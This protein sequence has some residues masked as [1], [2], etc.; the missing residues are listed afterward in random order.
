[1]GDMVTH[2]TTRQQTTGLWSAKTYDDRFAPSVRVTYGLVIKRHEAVFGERGKHLALL[3]SYN[4]TPQRI[5]HKC[6]AQ[7]LKNHSRAWHH[8]NRGAFKTMG[9]P[10]LLSSLLYSYVGIS[11]FSERSVPSITA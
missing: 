8:N 1:M 10:I 7:M 4:P 5:K 2:M 3:L 11:S 6:I 9:V